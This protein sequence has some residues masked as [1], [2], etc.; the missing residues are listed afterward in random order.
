MSI[1]LQRLRAFWGFWTFNQTQWESKNPWTPS[2]KENKKVLF[3]SFW[4]FW[5]FWAV[6][7]LIP[8]QLE[9]KNPGNKAA[10]HGQKGNKTS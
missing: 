2:K 9:S 5:E 10:T 6:W 7:A 3:Q 1:S 4:A 8:T